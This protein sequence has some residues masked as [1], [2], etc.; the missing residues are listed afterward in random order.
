MNAERVTAIL[1]REVGR[2]LPDCR[3]SDFNIQFCR[4]GVVTPYFNIRFRNQQTT[5]SVDRAFP[6]AFAELAIHLANG[7]YAE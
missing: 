4:P 5:V 6:E 3:L 2:L 1:M 7:R